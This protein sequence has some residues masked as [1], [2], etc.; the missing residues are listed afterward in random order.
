MAD[1]TLGHRVYEKVASDAGGNIAFAFIGSGVIWLFTKIWLGAAKVLFW[2]AAT[3]M[4][5]SVAHFTVVL[6]AGAIAWAMNA[7]QVREKWLWVSTA[8]RFF[9]QILNAHGSLAGCASGWVFPMRVGAHT[10]ES[11]SSGATAGQVPAVRP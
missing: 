9:E 5:L 4:A 1:D 6:L 7:P 3:L 8:I 11:A 2:V 10:V